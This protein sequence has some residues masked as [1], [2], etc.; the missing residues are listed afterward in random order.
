MLPTGPKV[1]FIATKKI[2][3]ENLRAFL[4][5]LI[6]FIANLVYV[7]FPPFFA[8][9]SKNKWLR[10]IYFEHKYFYLTQQRILKPKLRRVIAA[11]L[12]NNLSLLLRKQMPWL[13][14]FLSKQKGLRKIY[15]RNKHYAP[16][17]KSISPLVSTQYLFSNQ[18]K[19]ISLAL[20]QAMTS[21]PT[22]KRLYE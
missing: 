22:R 13:F 12:I 15:L 9:L 3:I 6:N 2:I 16:V 4:A 1:F 21:W 5:T 11:K 18:N 8:L 20:K 17:K 10:K 19:E 14:S 7:Y